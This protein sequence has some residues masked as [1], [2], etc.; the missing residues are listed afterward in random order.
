[1]RLVALNKAPLIH[2]HHQFRHFQH[3]TALTNL[4]TN[5]KSRY[6][7]LET[8]RLHSA[9]EAID[10]SVKLYDAQLWFSH[11]ISVQSSDIT[12]LSLGF[13]YA[14]GLLASFSPCSLSLLPLTL[15]YLGSSNVN[16]T[17]NDNVVGSNN[18]SDGKS[19]KTRIIMYAAGFASMLTFTGLSAALLG[20]MFGSA[21]S[22]LLGDFPSLLSGFI[23][24][25]MGLYLLNIIN[26]VLP[27]IDNLINNNSML[28]NV[29]GPFSA[30][31]LGGSSAFVAS[32]CSSPI[33]ASILSAIA[34]TGN[35]TQGAITLLSY[36]I[37]FITPLT[38][39]GALSSNVKDL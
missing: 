15:A 23:S 22:S 39:A 10:F 28:R 8:L 26:I 7:R 1:M 21:S 14:A 20:Q 36:S 31:L 6:A 11:A 17:D 12:I 35:P 37:G 29:Q 32:P 19:D 30:F 16:V 18:S 9:G 38:V 25:T 24:L 5:H 3:S 33:L 4:Q 13:L 27:T 2:S 34:T